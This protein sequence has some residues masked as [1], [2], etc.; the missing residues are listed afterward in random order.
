MTPNWETERTRQGLRRTGLSE[1]DNRESKVAKPERFSGKKGNEVYR[2]LAQLRLVFR[3]K[4][5]TYSSDSD[6]VAYAL[7]YMSRAAQNWAMPL[8]QALDEGHEHELLEDYDAFRESV[9]G[10]YGDLD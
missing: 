4:P 2:W 7:S 8:L 3:G 6:K 5:R 1:N 9:I 10:L